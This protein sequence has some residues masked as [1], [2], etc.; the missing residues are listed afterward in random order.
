MAPVVLA[1]RQQGGV[2]PIVCFTG[3]HRELLTQA[4]QYF[5]VT[6]DLDLD[7]M[8]PNQGLNGLLARC[9]E[10]LDDAISRY[11][12]DCLI[13]QG[14]TTTVAAAAMAG[15]HRGIPFAHVE[16]G[17]RTGNLQSPWPE[18]FNR[19]V[20][21]IAAAIHCAPTRR[22]AENLCREGIEAGTIH[23][24]G[25]TVIDALFFTLARERANHDQWLRK[26]PRL[27]D[28]RMVLVTGHRRENHGDVQAA[29]F[30]AIG[31]LADTFPDVSFI[32]PVHPNPTVRMA[33]QGALGHLPNVMLTPPADYPEFVWLMDQAQV[34]I[35]DSGG[36]QEEAP[37]LGKPVLVTR[38]TTERSEAVETGAATLVGRCPQRL[39]DAASKLLSA[40]DNGSR[41]QASENPYGD[42]MAGE[43]IARIITGRASIPRAA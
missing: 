28:H 30:A 34:I 17:L 2:E 27:T 16:A 15:F 33:A 25:N 10:G 8:R 5:G 21:S 18:E 42:G 26:Y 37:S 3:Q 41:R 39:F 13:A 11:E 31:H 38:D 40:V 23:V 4:A 12:P 22:A 19:R 9:L 6:P 1:L 24:T 20:A 36:V 7:L 43:R 14:D 29:L 32:F 35:T